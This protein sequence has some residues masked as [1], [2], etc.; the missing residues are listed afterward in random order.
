MES[1]AQRVKLPANP[2]QNLVFLD[3]G[4]GHLNTNVRR[5]VGDMPLKSSHNI[6]VYR[7]NGHSSF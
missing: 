2:G 1:I 7:K 5:T 6:W 4:R 3:R